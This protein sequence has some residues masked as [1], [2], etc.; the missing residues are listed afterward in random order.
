MTFGQYLAMK[1]RAAGLTLKEM[2]ALVKKE[3]GEPIS[4]QYLSEIEN[5]RRNPPSDHLIEAFAKVLRMESPYMLYI[6]ARRLPPVFEADNERQA[7]KA[8]KA[9][10][11]QLE[12][13]A[14]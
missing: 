2:A 9:L 13:I 4:F 10:L 11:R 6:K 7:V 12:S 1:R 14:A 5:D 3:D 8:T